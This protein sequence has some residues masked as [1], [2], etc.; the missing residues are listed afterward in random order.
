MM[1]ELGRAFSKAPPTDR[2]LVFMAVT[3]E[4]KGL[5]GSEYYAANPV[6]PL[7]TTAGVINMD[8]TLGPGAAKDLTISGVAQ[9]GLPDMRVNEAKEPGRRHP[10]DPRTAPGG[11]YRVA[12]FPCP[13]HGVPA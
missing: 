9:L 6:Y 4:E 10:P 2:A 3:A 12:P 11:L 1:L 7:A 8:S 13:N 5:L